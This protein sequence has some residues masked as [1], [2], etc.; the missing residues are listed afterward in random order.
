[1][2]KNGRKVN[3]AGRSE[4][5]P[6]F[7][8]LPFWMMESAAFLALTPAEICALLFLAK[9]YNGSNN[10]KIGFGVRS[11]CFV[12][13]QGTAALEDKPI[14]LA[15]SGIAR[16][17][18]TLEAFGFA[19]CTK[20]ATFD[21][22]R[23][24]REWRLTWLPTFGEA[25]TREFMSLSVQDCKLIRANALERNARFK[26]KKTKASPTSGTMNT[27][28]FPPEGLCP[29]EQGPISPLQ[30]HERDYETN[31]QSHQRDTSSN[32]GYGGEGSITTAP[33]PY[34]IP[35]FPNP[36]SSSKPVL[37]QP[38]RLLVVNGHEPDPQLLKDRRDPLLIQTGRCAPDPSQTDCKSPPAILAE[39]LGGQDQAKAV[40]Q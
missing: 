15:R 28:T 5:E 39:M 13:K 8:Q 38:P 29:T 30:S 33:V 12:P 11:G 4:G 10:G 19:A 25:A 6:R 17:L 20:P 9:R 35:F 32:Q 36:T 23:E 37:V 1:M 16:A 26:A 24:T 27:I 18:E 7:L 34:P 21:Q 40:A 31:L 2:A 22:K 3:K 14:P